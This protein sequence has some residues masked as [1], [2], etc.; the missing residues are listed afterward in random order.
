MSSFHTPLRYPGGKARLGPWLAFTMR[1]NGISGGT[2]M[3]PY[4]GGAGAAIFLLMCG[5]VRRIVI[6]DVDPAV[7]AFWHC[8]LH[9]CD[10]LVARI[11]ATPCTLETW[12]TQRQVLRAGTAQSSVLDLGFACF[13]M[14]RTNRSGILHGGVIGGYA[15]NAAN[16]IDARYN[17]DDLVARILR[18]HAKRGSITLYNLDALALLQGPAL[19]LRAR[20]LLYLDPPYYVKGQQ[21]YRNAYAPEDHA[22]IAAAV[23]AVPTPWLVT[24]DNAPEVAALYAD[25]HGCT[26]DLTYSMHLDRPRA[27]ERLFHSGLA[28]P[29]APVLSRRVSG[30]PPAWT[31]KAAQA[32]AA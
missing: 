15:Q 16:N 1:H 7:H 19:E 18:I 2:Y 11:R 4:A 28:M 3:E 5:Y 9:D 27:T 29:V 26:F 31:R 14:N 32:R 24:Y 22:A 13:F 30:W 12:R 6:N 23:Q 17:V 21:L 20:S 8:V 25:A 10:R